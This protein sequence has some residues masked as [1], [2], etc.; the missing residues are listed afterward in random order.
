MSALFDSRQR[1]TAIV[2]GLVCHLSFLLG[3]AAMIAGLFFGMTRGFGP[4]HGSAAWIADGL[5]LLQFPLVH[6]FLLSQRGGRLLAR[7]TPLGLGSDLRTTTY[8]T[9]SSWQL[10]LVFGLW[11]PI[12]AIWWEPTG[13][14]LAVCSVL[15]AAS[16]I[17]LL[18][19]MADA[20]LPLQTGFLGWSAVAR[21]R[22]PRFKRFP[23]EGTFGLI[24]QPVYFAFTLTLWTAPVWTADRLLIAV[25]WTA[26][27]L[28]GPLLKEQ[29][30]L[31]YHGNDFAEYR[32]RVPYWVPRLTNR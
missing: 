16:W 15:Y 19:T 11:S 18:K 2:A 22:K 8:A 26:Y 31:R 20:G 28:L 1:F 32:R 6:S 25:A 10:M 23:V 5:L 3:I 21:N 27:C 9:V 30:Y 14:A 24:R 29:R 13:L 4:F 7:L 17:L 12:G